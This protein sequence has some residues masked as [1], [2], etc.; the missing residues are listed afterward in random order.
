MPWD[1]FFD[2]FFGP[3]VDE[4]T[5]CIEPLADIA[6]T[7]EE[8]VITVDLPFVKSK[9]DI[10]V[11][12]SDDGVEITAKTRRGIKWNKWSTHYRYTEFNQFKKRIKLPVRVD[13]DNVR[14]F[15]RNGILTIKLRKKKERVQITLD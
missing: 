13:P 9:E 2:E 11:Y 7:D 5:K 15:F 8:I 6:E 12:V 3:S 1:P 14:A 4:G 10:D